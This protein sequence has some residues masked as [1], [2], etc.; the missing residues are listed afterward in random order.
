MPRRVR[1]PPELLGVAFDVEQGRA[2]GLGTERLRS[3]DLAR[4]FHG[5]R[6]SADASTLLDRCRSYAKRMRSSEF[7]SHL[8]AAELWGIPLPRQWSRGDPLHV[9]TVGSVRSS[10][11]RGIVGHQVF[12]ER[13]IT[14]SREGFRVADAASTWCHL[15]GILCQY[16]LVAAADYLVLDPPVPDRSEKRPLV[17]LTE[18]TDRVNSYRGRGCRR[19][20]AA[21]VRVRAGSESPRETLLRLRLVDAGLPE[22]ELGVDVFAHDGRW[23]ARL[24]MF[25]R[26]WRVAVEYDG[27]QHRTDSRQYDRDI[28]RWDELTDADIR[29][30]RIRKSAMEGN[31]ARAVHLVRLALRKAG[32]PY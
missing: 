28:T 19:A 23:I 2:H 26:T 10:K 31:A 14:T 32:A 17:T 30:V 13:V 27:D 9:A 22:P 15:A 25:Y 18:L 11:C 16:D 6:S 24:D 7:F 12:D 3:G 29:L 20:R 21:L 5:V 4:P 8:T 1:L